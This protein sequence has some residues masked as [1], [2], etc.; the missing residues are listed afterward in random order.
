MG[1]RH[2]LMAT[3]ATLVAFPCG[4]A[5]QEPQRLMGFTSERAAEQLRWERVMA[6]VPDTATMREY[7]FAMTRAPHHA[8]TEEN[9]RLAT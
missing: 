4:L 7:H 1:S 8:G 9:Y 6:A 5:G 3:V 2:V